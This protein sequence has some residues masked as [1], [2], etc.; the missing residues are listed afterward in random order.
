MMVEFGGRVLESTEIKECPFSGITSDS[1]DWK[2]GSRKQ[3]LDLENLDA[4]LYGHPKNESCKYAPVRLYLMLSR[5]PDL[6]A[7]TKG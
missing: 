2:K 1:R 4:H 7:K 6:K 5:I 3:G